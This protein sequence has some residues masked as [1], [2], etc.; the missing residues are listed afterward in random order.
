VEAT[1]DLVKGL[2]FVVKTIAFVALQNKSDDQNIHFLALQ[3]HSVFSSIHIPYL[4][5]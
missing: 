4:S 2:A 5:I 3:V 1:M